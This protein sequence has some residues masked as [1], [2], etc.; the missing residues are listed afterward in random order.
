MDIFN[1]DKLSLF[2]IFFIPGFISAKVWSFLIASEVKKPSE[3]IL[4]TISY[5]CMNFA[6]LWWL[7]SFIGDSTSKENHIFLYY[8]SVFLVLIG[9]P[10][11]WPFIL[12]AVRTS[13]FLKGNT[14]H[15]IPKAW[16]YILGMGKPLFVLV[17]LKNGNMIGGLYGDR[18]FA[19]SYPAS[20]D[21]YLQEVWPVDNNGIFLDR[22][23]DT[24]GLW[25]SK[26]FINYLEFFE[27]DNSEK[28]G[29]SNEEQTTE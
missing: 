24:A 18:S 17:H 23:K 25:I 20:E 7:I 16:D 3:F 22:V 15:P 19:S 21:I 28:G 8:L 1:L 29:T 4:E 6:L 9:F 26:D 14:I 13:S 10:V 27:I 2:A 12:R 11:I 5:S